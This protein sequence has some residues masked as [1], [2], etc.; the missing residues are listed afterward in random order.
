MYYF[1]Q[2]SGKAKKWQ[3]CLTIISFLANKAKWQPCIDRVELKSDIF[4][5]LFLQFQL[6]LNQI[7]E[8]QNTEYKKKCWRP[9]F[10]KTWRQFHQ[11][12]TSS[13]YARRDPKAQKAA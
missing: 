10:N 4:V 7:Q 5:L 8:G 11:H 1:L 3:N 9:I 6:L 2:H 13:F 12:S